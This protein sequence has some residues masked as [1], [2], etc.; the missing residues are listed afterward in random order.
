MKNITELRDKILTLRNY[1]V[2]DKS[3]ER[4]LLDRLN[5]VESKLNKGKRKL[6]FSGHGID[7]YQEG[8]LR[9]IYSNGNKI[10]TEKNDNILI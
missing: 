5:T 9:V 8:H 3:C 2:I 10:F 4:F 1:G 7:I 6:L